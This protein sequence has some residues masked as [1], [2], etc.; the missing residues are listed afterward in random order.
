MGLL[1]LLLSPHLPITFPWAGAEA[2][3]ARGR[4]G[5][6]ARLIT[7][8]ATLKQ[9]Y[10]YGGAPYHVFFAD[11]RASCSCAARTAGKRGRACCA[12]PFSPRAPHKRATA[13]PASIFIVNSSCATLNA[14]TLEC[15]CASKQL[16]GAHTLGDTPR[17]RP[18]SRVD[19]SPRCASSPQ[20]SVAVQICDTEATQRSP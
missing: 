3:L 8:N 14:V 15:A 17:K 4:R 18:R 16:H 11:P 10:L 9:P 6:A 1:P 2:T 7:V 20:N 5:G 12:R 19:F 13:G